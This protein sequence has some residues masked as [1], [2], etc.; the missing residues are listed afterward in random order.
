MR[1][2][3]SSVITGME[4]ERNAAAHAVGVL[5]HQVMRA[6][7]FGASSASPQQTCLAGVRASDAVLLLMGGRYGFQQSSGLSA[8]HEEYREA[9]EVRPV[10]VFVQA[11]VE[12]DSDQEAFLQEVQ[13]W[14]SGHYS[15]SF[16]TPD[17]L[18]DVVSRALHQWEISQTAGPVDEKEMLTRATALIPGLSDSNE[19]VLCLVTVGGPQRQVLRPAELENPALARTITQQALFGSPSVFDS[20]YGT[21]AR[22][23]GHT[24]VVAQPRSSILVDELGSVRLV[25]PA[26]VSQERRS[27]LDSAVLIE[28][29][30]RERLQRAMQFSAW[31]LDQLDGPKRLSDVVILA[32][33]VHCSRYA[34][35]SR[36][37]HERSTHSMVMGKGTDLIV[38]PL[39]PPLRNRAALAFDTARLAEDLT[40]LF[41]REVQV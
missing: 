28:E 25:Q 18:R 22:L 34:W 3:L 41:R 38:C 6:E 29:D 7:D 23:A 20:E 27:G 36:A 35:R 17:E 32:A 1:I 11:G 8:T 14:S 19:G 33:L 31:L 10:L 39:T 9:R 15:A 13:E 4:A 21:A 30:I 2:F 37:E 5:G 26:I 12:R 16:S 40:V 24:L